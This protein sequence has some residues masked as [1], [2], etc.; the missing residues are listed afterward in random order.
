MTEISKV[1]CNFSFGGWPPELWDPPRQGSLQIR[2]ELNREDIVARAEEGGRKKEEI[3]SSDLILHSS[4]LPT[5][6]PGRL[7]RVLESLP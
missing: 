7:D 2:G 6:A 1:P 5:Y 3:L 4:D